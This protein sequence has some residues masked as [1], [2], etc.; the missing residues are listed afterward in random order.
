MKKILLMSTLGLLSWDTALA[1]TITIDGVIDETPG[2]TFSASGSGLEISFSGNGKNK[3][4]GNT[5]VFGKGHSGFT[6]GQDTKLYIT[7]DQEKKDVFSH[8]DPTSTLLT[9]K[10]NGLKTSHSIG[11][12]RNIK[13]DPKSAVDRR[14]R[15]VVKSSP[16]PA[17]FRIDI[18]PLE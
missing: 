9:I 3:L 7:T 6:F 5:K 2:Q 15:I 14:Y 18:E 8:I 4:E 12:S 17:G 1:E 13:R 11:S 10:V 16:T